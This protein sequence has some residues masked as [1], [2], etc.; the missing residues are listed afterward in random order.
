MKRI[1][2]HTKQ[3]IKQGLKAV[4]LT[5]LLLMCPGWES[6]GSAQTA[7][8]APTDPFAS[9]AN[10]LYQTWLEMHQ[11]LPELL[12]LIPALAGGPHSQILFASWRSNTPENH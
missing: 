11:A 3:R 1:K 12:H 5:G 7:N 9:E 8:K 6:D 10:P 4:G 2:P